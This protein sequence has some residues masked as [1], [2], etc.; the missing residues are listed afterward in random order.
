MDDKIYI[1]KFDY[2]QRK[3]QK[4]YDNSFGKAI[5]NAIAITTNNTRILAHRE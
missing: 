3:K 4:A 1:I 5:G 2:N